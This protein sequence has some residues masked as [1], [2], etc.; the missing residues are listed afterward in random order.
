MQTLAAVPGSSSHWPALYITA[1]FYLT[2][3]P[4][5]SAFHKVFLFSVFIVQM[6]IS[7]RIRSQLLQISA[8]SQRIQVCVSARRFQWKEQ[9]HGSTH[10]TPAQYWRR[11]MEEGNYAWGGLSESPPHLWSKLNNPS[12]ATLLS[13][14][15][16]CSV[17]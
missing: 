11:T 2:T 7:I 1:A 16:L 14:F 17:H 10:D 15:Q 13:D 9:P 12:D 3:R 8:F 4:E 6:N 5:R